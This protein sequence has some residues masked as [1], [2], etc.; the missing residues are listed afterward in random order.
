MSAE[1]SARAV[2][3]LAA[4]CATRTEAARRLCPELVEALRE[5]GLFRIC[6]PK[7]LGGGEV[8]PAEMVAAIETLGRADG[9][10]AWCVAVA[11]TSGAVAAYLPTE[12]AREVYGDP[13]ACVG[14]VFAPKGRAVQEGEH[15]SVTGRWPFASGVEHSD[16]LM[17]GCL[18]EVDGE[19]RTL[20]SGVPDIRLSLVP[21]DRVEVIDTWSV[22]GLRGTGSHDMQ[23]TDLDVPVA[24]SASLLSGSPREEGALYAFPVFGLLALAIASTALGIA[25]GAVGDLVELAAGKTPAMASRSLAEQPD[26][27]A[28]VARAE[29]RLR[30]ARALVDEAVGDAY[31]EAES[32]RAVSL[33]RRAGLRMAAS[34]AMESAAAVVDEM[35]ALAGGS[36]IYDSSP[37]QRRFRDVHVATQH[38]LVGPSVWQLAGRV[39]LGQPVRSD[40]L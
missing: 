12:Q 17:G 19:V 9:A 2:A 13:R 39:L 38:M 18:V 28:R 5:S 40:Q 7:A 15:L 1:E 30:S 25:R 33:E 11:A 8:G 20:E 6:V 22:T 35:Y 10:A 32:E 16:W 4:E 36:S 14:G 24:R 31:G 37:L 21:A 3:P 29:A 34:H 27:R 26:T 23:V